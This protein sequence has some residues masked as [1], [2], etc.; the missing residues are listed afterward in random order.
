M[1]LMKIKARM[2][3]SEIEPFQC[4]Y[5]AWFNKNLELPACIYLNCCNYIGT[6]CVAIYC[7]MMCSDAKEYLLKLSGY[8]RVYRSIP[9]MYPI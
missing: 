4:N 6:C 1:A 3:G 8:S 9:C 5:S 2:K 7:T